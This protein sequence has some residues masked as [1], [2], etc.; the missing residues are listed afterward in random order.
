MELRF[1]CVGLRHFRDCTNLTYPRDE[2]RSAESS[3]WSVGCWNRYMGS[4]AFTE[5]PRP[6]MC[7]CDC[8]GGP[9]SLGVSDT[10]RF[11]VLSFPDILLSRPVPISLDVQLLRND[12]HNY[13]AML[14][15]LGFFRSS[16]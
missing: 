16:V 6:E 4:G 3:A 8:K 5:N 9:S 15:P 1:W 7:T 13:R 12:T 14:L 10:E 11:L 2:D